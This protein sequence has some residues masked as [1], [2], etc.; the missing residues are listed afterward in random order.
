MTPNVDA[1]RHVV[2]G[3]MAACNYIEIL[4]YNFKT[5]IQKFSLR[6]SFVFH[7]GNDCKHTKLANARVFTIQYI[8]PYKNTAS[9]TGH[10]SDKIFMAPIRL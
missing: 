7:Q 6:K 3:T 1:N 10:T 9:I 4:C 2:E 8:T 5:S